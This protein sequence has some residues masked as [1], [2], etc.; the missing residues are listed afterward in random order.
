MDIQELASRLV[1]QEKKRLLEEAMAIGFPAQEYQEFIG[2]LWNSKC[3][4]F[5]CS[6]I[7]W[8]PEM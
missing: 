5:I 6:E 1:M 2:I 8:L 3:F 4:V 7:S